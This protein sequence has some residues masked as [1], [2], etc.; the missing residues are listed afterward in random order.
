MKTAVENDKN[1]FIIWI[2]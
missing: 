2:I 1:Y